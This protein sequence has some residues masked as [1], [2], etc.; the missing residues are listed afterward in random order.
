MSRSKP[1]T[2]LTYVCCNKNA[3]EVFEYWDLD[4]FKCTYFIRVGHT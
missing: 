4:L 3:D 2:K 1:H